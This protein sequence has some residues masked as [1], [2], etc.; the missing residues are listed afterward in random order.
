MKSLPDQEGIEVIC[1]EGPPM[2]PFEDDEAIQNAQQG[3][4]LCRHIVIEPDGSE[5]EYKVKAQ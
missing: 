5:S 3:C 1:C 2:C 4:P